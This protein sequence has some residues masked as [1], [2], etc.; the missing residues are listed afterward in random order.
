MKIS[1]LLFSFAYTAFLASC[2]SSQP[3]ATEAQSTSVNDVNHPMPQA[4][5]STMPPKK[6]PKP[7]EIVSQLLLPDIN[8][9][10]APATVRN[11]PAKLNISVHEVPARD[12]FMGLVVDTAENM[13]VH[14]D[15]KGT[16]SLDLKNVTIAQ[17]LDAI[18][19]VYGYDY[20]KNE[21]GY[22][23]YPASLQTKTFKIDHIDL[24]R[25]GVSNTTVSS[26][27]SSNYNN[28]QQQTNQLGMQ[29]N[30]TQSNQ[31]TTTPGAAINQNLPGSSIKS[32]TDTDFWHELDE[33]LHSIIA[34]DK[35]AT[36]F[37]NKQSGMII[38]RAKPTQ[39]REIENFISATQN[40]ISRQVILE[41]KILE[42]T[43]NDTHKDGIDWKSIVREGLNT[44]PVLT[45]AA[46][47]IYLASQAG[48]FRAGDFSALVSLLETQG[49][50]KVLSSPRI[51]T[52][53][54]QQAIIKV[55]QDSSFVTGISPGIVGGLNGGT[56]QP[57]PTL[58]SFFSGIA[59]DVTPQI[60]DN[61]E[62]TLHIHPSITTVESLD[63]KYTIDSNGT[64]SSIPTALNTIR[65]SDSIVKAKDNQVIVLGGLMQETTDENKEG[66]YGFAR[67][68][69]LGNLFRKDTG[70]L[71]K[72]ELI[73]LLKASIVDNDNDWNQ[74]ISDSKLRARQIDR[75]PRW[76]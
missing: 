40:Q 38:A 49:K 13:V 46:G 28:N 64:Q 19:K 15:V 29:A 17:V 6:T 76:Q 23:I 61:D 9:T 63:R 27:Q 69:Y 34:I 12:F 66:V 33:A 53:N 30:T 37:I 47:G 65:E 44:A 4:A 18:Q 56:V 35:E 72:T 21:I 70:K 11:Q 62:V 68:P 57:A 54:N 20:K 43:L 41:A 22:I 71:E 8:E 31:G 39:L 26:G 45:G 60:N 48:G 51:S 42:V 10:L 36:V 2:A 32:T 7:P 25:K 74:E 50:T 5:E 75:I 1:T 59:L 3:A 52:L 67:I 16:I 55:G 14:P 58:S 24:L 73:I